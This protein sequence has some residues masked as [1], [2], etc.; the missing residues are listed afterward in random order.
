MRED[1]PKDILNVALL[2][3]ERHMW[4]CVYGQGSC[5]KW[6]AVASQPCSFP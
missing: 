2:S 5:A 4:V 3:A 1:S 6:L